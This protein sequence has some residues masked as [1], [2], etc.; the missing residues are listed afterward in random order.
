MAMANPQRGEVVLSIDGRPR[1]MRLTL[2][3][4]A[5]LEARLG[6]G[7]LVALAER[8]EGGEVGAADLVALLAAGLSGA[9]EEM[10]EAEIA[11]AEIE[12]GA[13]AAL[14]AGLALLAGA[15]RP[16]DP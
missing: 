16:G 3:A 5:A 6:A 14:S 7:G 10:T 13:S 8:F 4:L 12:G 1:R 15:F 9:G 2:G 11:A